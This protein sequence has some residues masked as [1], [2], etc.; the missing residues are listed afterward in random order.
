MPEI[1]YTP[2]YQLTRGGIVESLHFGAAAV[3]AADGR[4]IASVGEPNMVT[5]MRSSA[6]PFQAMPFVE[7]GGPDYFGFSL[8]ETALTCASHSGTDDHAATAQQIQRRAGF[9]ESDLQCGTHLPTNAETRLRMQ[10][11]GEEPTSNRHNCSGKH[12]G[13]LSFA[14]MMDWPL[15]TYLE[16]DSLLQQRILQTLSE[17]SS[18]PADKITVGIDGCSAPNFALPLYN[19]ALAYARLSDPKDLPTPRAGACRR[20]TQAMS[21]HPDMIAGPGE[22]DTLLMTAGEGRLVSKGGAE[23]YQAIGLLPGAL[24][25][26]SPGIGITT[27]ISDGSARRLASDAFSLAIL[28]KLGLDLP[29]ETLSPFG[30]ALSLKNYRKLE[31]GTASPCFELT[32][33]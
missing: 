6:K 3:V 27:K 18:R 7:A 26:G 23:G 31:V 1:E 5:F 12:S 14:R 24:G 2:V 15:K 21:T 30:P 11:A 16:T 19:A 9:H 22:F 28:H 33:P 10:V 25:P 8:K 13:M 32:R 4:L 29:W 20:I 17:M